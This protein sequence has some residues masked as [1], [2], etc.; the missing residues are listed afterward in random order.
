MRLESSFDVPRTLSHISIANLIA[1]EHQSITLSIAP[2]VSAIRATA[3]AASKMH[4]GGE[5]VRSVDVSGSEYQL[6]DGRYLGVTQQV[7][8]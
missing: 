2:D 3:R 8:Q 6:D 5:A 1:S 7:Q 4:V